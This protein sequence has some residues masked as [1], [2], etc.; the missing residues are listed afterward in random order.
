M[1]KRLL[2]IDFYVGN[3]F[4]PAGKGILPWALSEWGDREKRKLMSFP[5]VVAWEYWYEIT[6]HASE[7]SIAPGVGKKKGT[8]LVSQAVK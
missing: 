4:S 5:L 7:G 1:L 3:L 6:Y 2:Y 8:L